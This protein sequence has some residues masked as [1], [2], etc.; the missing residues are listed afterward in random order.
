MVY[1]RFFKE[2]NVFLPVWLSSVFFIYFVIINA[3][4]I[5]LSVTL[6]L[7]FNRHI[8][9]HSCIV[10]NCFIAD[11]KALQWPRKLGAFRGA[12][13]QGET[14]SCTRACSYTRIACCAVLCCVRD[15]NDPLSICAT[16]LCPLLWL[17]QWLQRSIGNTIH[18]RQTS[19][20]GPRQE[21]LRANRNV[22]TK[23]VP[24]GTFSAWGPSAGGWDWY[25]QQTYG[26]AIASAWSHPVSP[27]PGCPRWSSTLPGNSV[28]D[29]VP[30]IT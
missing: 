10:A 1:C 14:D 8:Y 25:L 24:C 7:W 28:F 22:E 13:I 27:A 26:Y 16:V 12:D 11:F 30:A 23:T 5:G 2:P 3:M 6:P 17:C 18:T 21:E 20:Q 4:L 19:N 15:C 9:A 29:A